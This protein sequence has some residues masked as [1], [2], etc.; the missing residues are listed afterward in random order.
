MEKGISQEDDEKN[1]NPQSGL[2]S[3]GT[4]SAI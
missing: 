4:P 1:K 2:R 3:E